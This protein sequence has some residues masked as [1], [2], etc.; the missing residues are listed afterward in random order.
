MF[1]QKP[2]W[3]QQIDQNLYTSLIG[4]GFCF[5]QKVGTLRPLNSLIISSTETQKPGNLHIF[6]DILFAWSINGAAFV[7]HHSSIGGFSSLTSPPKRS[8]CVIGVR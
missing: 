5:I 1:Q 8:P 6:C 2:L 3:E 7:Y 4:V